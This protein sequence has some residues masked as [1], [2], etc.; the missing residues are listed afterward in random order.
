M[1]L[2]PTLNNAQ[3]RMKNELETTEKCQLRVQYV[4]SLRLGQ[5]QP[6]DFLFYSCECVKCRCAQDFPGANLGFC[7]CVE[8]ALEGKIYW[9]LGN[10]AGS[11]MNNLCIT[12]RRYAGFTG[13]E[14]QALVTKQQVLSIHYRVQEQVAKQAEMTFHSKNRLFRDAESWE[15]YEPSDA[16]RNSWMEEMST[17]RI[18]EKRKTGLRRRQQTKASA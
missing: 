5:L 14:T 2:Y 1:M 16:L 4:F 6:E 8:M 9:K 7:Q 11:A 15:L 10:T 17:Q 3:Y 12:G 18:A 13:T